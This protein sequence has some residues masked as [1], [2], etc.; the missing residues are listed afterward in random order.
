MTPATVYVDFHNADSRG[1]IRL[2][3]VGTARDLSENQIELTEGLKLTLSDG[4]LE[5]EGEVQFAEGEKLWVAA[6]DW[7]ALHTNREEPAS[8]LIP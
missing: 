6:I 5:A 3:C 7:K 8:T 2:N 1:R 4:E